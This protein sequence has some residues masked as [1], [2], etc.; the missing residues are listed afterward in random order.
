MSFRKKKSKKTSAKAVI[1][2][3]RPKLEDGCVNRNHVC[4]GKDR[5][6]PTC[7][8]VYCDKHFNREIHQDYCKYRAKED[9]ELLKK[10]GS[11]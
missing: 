4:R 10:Y 8:M 7:S 9:L 6:C 1:I 2:D 5:V 11:T 3:S